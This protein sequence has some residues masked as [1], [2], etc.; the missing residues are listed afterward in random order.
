MNSEKTP[1]E[2]WYNDLSKN[3]KEVGRYKF[4]FIHPPNTDTFGYLEIDS[5]DGS[6][7]LMLSNYLITN[8]EATEIRLKY[9][10]LTARKELVLTKI[11]NIEK[12][13]SFMYL[14][15]YDFER[16]LNEGLFSVVAF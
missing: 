12:E 14:S 1:K 10:S 13:G 11:D 15:R 5:L 9:I 16:A 2:N 3:P 4:S 8:D 6:D 7:R